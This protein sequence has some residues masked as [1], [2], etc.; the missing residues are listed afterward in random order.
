MSVIDHA[1]TETAADEAVES[2]SQPEEE[3]GHEAEHEEY[4]PALNPKPSYWPILLGTL[5]IL[6]PIGALLLIWGGSQ[7]A[8]LGWVSL[9]LGG[10]LCLIPSLG[11][12]HAI[13][14]D[15]WEGHF[16]VEAQGKDLSMGVKLFFLSEIAIFGS[17]FGYYFGQY[18]FT[19]S[20]G[21]SFPPAGTPMIGT[22]LP[23]LGL[24]VLLTSSVTAEFAHKA[25]VHGKRGRCKDWMLITMLLG[26]G[27]LFMQGWEWG[28]LITAGSFTLTTNWFS[29]LFYALT[30]FHGLHV[31]TGLML[32]MLVY[33]RLEIGH[34]TQKRHFSMLAASWYWHLVDVVWVFVF[35]FVYAFLN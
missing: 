2:L 30:G 16:G 20:Q 34:Y 17:L 4:L 9:A 32:L 35:T 10:L 23:A 26:L 25:L 11:W 1:Q 8:F 7:Y 29:T 28:H 31:M 24:I 19:T 5:V 21:E 33:G 6:L 12:A 27:F 3:P 18:L 22:G 13:I 14:V 15:K